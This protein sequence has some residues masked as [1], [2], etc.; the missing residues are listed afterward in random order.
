MITNENVQY[1]D[2]VLKASDPV[3]KWI[4]DFI[5]SDNP[6]FAGKTKEERRKMA[7]GAYYGAQKESYDYPVEELEEARGRPPKEGSKAWHT[8]K[9]KASSGEGDESYEADKNIRT[10]LQKAISVGKPVTFN[11]GETKK[12]EP[13]HA[14]KA[15]SLLDNTPKPVD[16][17]NIQKSL[18]HSHDRFHATI[19]SGKPV[20]D[21]ARP[22]VTLGKMKAESVDPSTERA[23][24]GSITVRKIRKPDGSYVISHSKKGHGFYGDVVDAKEQYELT[25][26]DTI[27]LNKLYT[28]LSESNKLLFEEK[29]TTKDGIIDLINFAND[30]GF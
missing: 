17:E 1:L 10:Q 16:K 13:S 19:K 22:K 12:I 2:E 7:L 29:M 28:N 26:E 11:N 3:G 20:V 14:H 4:D 21:A 6:K 30:Q 8:A 27:T 23:D 9:A 24:K 18:G 5:H 25:S 15:L